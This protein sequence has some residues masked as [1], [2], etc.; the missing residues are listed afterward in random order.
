VMGSPPAT[1]PERSPSLGKT[2]Y[3]CLE[4]YH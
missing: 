4:W 3:K 2:Y 1:R